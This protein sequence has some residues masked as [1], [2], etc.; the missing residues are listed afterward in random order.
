MSIDS[1]WAEPK[2][3]T[4]RDRQAADL[5]L[6]THV[7]YSLDLYLYSSIMMWFTILLR[8]FLPQSTYNL[9]RLTTRL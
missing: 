2:T 4:P 5:Y 1:N 6:K 3:D 8:M 7:S 9:T